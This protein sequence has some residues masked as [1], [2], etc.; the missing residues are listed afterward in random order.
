[1]SGSSPDPE[2]SER[3]VWSSAFV[4]E[5]PNGARV[6]T[7][8]AS[9]P[10]TVIW[11]GPMLTLALAR[12]GNAPTPIAEIATARSVTARS[13]TAPAVGDAMPVTTAFIVSSIPAPSPRGYD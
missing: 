10:V 4:N 1:M 12:P 2:I 9:C 7:A 3:T 13:R 5:M 6:I 8:P 11:F